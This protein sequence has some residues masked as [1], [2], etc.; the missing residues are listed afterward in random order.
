MNRRS[1]DQSGFISIDGQIW[2][3]MAKNAITSSDIPI[4]VITGLSFIRASCASSASVICPDDPV[5]P[6][7]LPCIDLVSLLNDSFTMVV[8][9]DFVLPTGKITCNRRYLYGCH[10]LAGSASC[11]V[12]TDRVRMRCPE[13]PEP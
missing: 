6:Y 3:A 13:F 7:V 9:P 10:S 8:S 2:N 11:F 5:V 1:L 4:L 12:P